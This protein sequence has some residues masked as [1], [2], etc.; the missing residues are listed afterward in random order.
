MKHNLYS[1]VALLVF[2]LVL[3]ISGC[4]DKKNPVDADADEDFD[5]YFSARAEERVWDEMSQLIVLVANNDSSSKLFLVASSS[6]GTIQLTFRISELRT[7]IF[8][9]SSVSKPTKHSAAYFD[10]DSKE[11]ISDLHPLG[12]ACIITTYTKT[13]IE[14][15]FEFYGQESETGHQ[16]HITE[17][18]FGVK[19]GE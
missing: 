3:L 6:S 7:G 15:I 19:L 10:K 2:S 9:L 12:G 1:F 13:A 4:S 14:G 8:H 17:G 18:K 5:T 16:V 11:Y